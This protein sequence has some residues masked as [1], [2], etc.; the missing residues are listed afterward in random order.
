[1]SSARLPTSYFEK[2]FLACVFTVLS[3]INKA[4]AISRLDFPERIQHAQITTIKDIEFIF[5][6]F[7]SDTWDAIFDSEMISIRTSADQSYEQ[8][9]DDSGVEVMNQGDIR[10]VMKRVNTSDSFWGADVYV[11][12]ENNSKENITV[13]ARDVSINGFMIDPIFSSDVISGKKSFDTITFFES[14][15]EKNDIKSID[16]MEIS[17]HIFESDGWDTILDTEMISISFE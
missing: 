15:L 5:H 10:I 3:L 11:Y 14:D 13:Q 9:Y 17:F 1:M 4:P 8:K 2:I 7:N 12:I 6:I 16:D